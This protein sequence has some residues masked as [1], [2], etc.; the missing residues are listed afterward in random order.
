MSSWL[1]WDSVTPLVIPAAARVVMPYRNGL[2]AWPPAMVGYFRYA[3]KAFID[4][5]GTDPEGCAVLDVETGDATPG[6]VPGWLGRKPPGSGCVYCNRSTLPAVLDAGREHQFYI[7][8]ATLDGT[9]PDAAQ[10]GLAASVTHAFTQAWG[11]AQLGFNADLSVIHDA[12]WLT[13]IGGTP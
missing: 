4:V 8:I 9:I 2:Y 3:A 7:G 6:Q 10:L 5:T 11:A 12:G 13:R 1:M